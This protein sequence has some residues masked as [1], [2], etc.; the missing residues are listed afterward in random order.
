M[1]PLIN[2]TRLPGR[3][4]GAAATAI[5]V[6]LSAF[7][8]MRLSAVPAR[9]DT[10]DQKTVQPPKTIRQIEP[11]FTFTIKT[12]TPQGQP[13]AGV[14]IHCV[15]PRPE[16]G[17][18][19]VD[20]TVATNETGTA[21]FVVQNANLLTDRY[22][23][24]DMADAGFIS[25][26]S[27]GISP[28]D[29]EFEWTFKTW[30][31]QER[32]L[33]IVNDQGLS[34]AG[35]RVWL[36]APDVF[37]GASPRT[38]DPEGRL[39]VKCPQ[40]RLAIAALAPGYAATVIENVQLA[41]PDAYVIR[42][43]PGREIRGQVLD[44]RGRPASAMVVRAR[45]QESFYF[46][47]EFIPQ[48]R[49]DAE[50]HF[51][52]SHLSRGD[53]EIIARSETPDQPFF[54]APVTV[55]VAD[56]KDVQNL[57]LT[58]QEGFRIKGKYV[59]KYDTRLK[60]R[61][62]RHTISLL[63]DAP[64]RAS[65]NEQTRED[66]TFDIWGLPCA[67]AGFI[68]FVGVSGFHQVIKLPQAQP[69]FQVNGRNIRFENVPP[70]TYE[71]IEVHFLLAGRVEGIVT[72]ASGNPL[73]DMEVIVQ[74]PGFLEKVNKEG[75]F[76]AQAA[77]GEDVTV[78]LR[79]SQDQVLLITEPFRVQEGEIVE[80]NLMVTGGAYGPAPSQ[81]GRQMPALSSL[82]VDVRPETL[83]GKRV[84]LCFFDMNQ[85][86]SR[87]FVLELAA[88]A[89]DL[90]RNNV[91]TFLVHAGQGDKAAVER[92]LRERGVPFTTGAVRGDT[93]KLLKDWTVQALPW[94]V[95]LDEKHALAAT[96]FDLQQLDENLKGGSLEQLPVALDWRAKFDLVYRLEEGQ[97]LKRIAP[98]FIRERQQYY[99]TEHEGQAAAIP[100][101][102]DQF[103]FHWDGGLRNWGMSF[104]DRGRLG[105]TLSF[106]LNL[107]SYEY[108]GAEDLL[109]L[110]LP[111]DWIIRHETS[112]ESKLKALEQLLAGEMGR[113]IRFEKR[114]IE[115]EVLVATG[116][117]EF[118]QLPGPFRSG[119]VIMCTDETDHAEREGGG[120]GTADSVR[121]FVEAVGNRVGMPVVDQTE[122]TGTVR[123]GY[124]YH[125]SS[126]LT[127]VKDPAE[128]AGKL[129][130]LLESLSQ[131]TSLQ[132][133]VERRLAEKWFVVEDKAGSAVNAPSP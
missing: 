9:A 52:L 8:S 58:A 25:S 40:A 91:V 55:F 3:V 44:P 104:G 60:G 20:M 74:P 121:E 43:N 27:V 129:K 105:S 131:Q 33:R 47:E 88:R 98:P 94:P 37:L 78:T 119:Q 53:W 35:A 130:I 89:R 54:V 116:R 97:I 65:W 125:S 64:Q 79:K 45:R 95:L 128:K 19:L 10:S 1:N 83:Q 70:G 72:D 85:R 127:R 42:L 34:I 21:Q 61:G 102:P 126:Y 48:A 84:L 81:A 66:G 11:P 12:T 82:G 120:G 56:D 15:H 13:Q 67:G 132:F 16:R 101:G 107:K 73:P 32:E 30:P 69:F 29:H 18:A 111:G 100:R 90:E 28:L 63:V 59:T 76:T 39:T 24:F 123:I 2:R 124:S 87:H 118:H 41:G 51:T 14:R 7:A 115:Q 99:T 31:L 38:T 117:Y 68:G 77:P 49:T 108:E 75:R 36:D 86:P 93:T 106:V 80:K 46:L 133:Q 17:K 57:T 96:G 122:P 62:A 113:N 112:V 5:F 71:G 26:G 92:W 103:V 109:N 110:E 6:T 23:W 114:A 22:F 4:T 50:G